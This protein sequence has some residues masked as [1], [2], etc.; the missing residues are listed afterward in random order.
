M[1]SCNTWSPGD[2]LLWLSIM[3]SRSIHCNALLREKNKRICVIIT[4]GTFSQNHNILNCAV[5]YLGYS[6]VRL[7]LLFKNF[8]IFFFF[9]F[10]YTGLSYC[11]WDLVPWPGNLCPLHWEHRVLATDLPGKSLG[12]LIL[13]H[14]SLLTLFNPKMLPSNTWFLETSMESLLLEIDTLT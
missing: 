7:T 2:W 11:M 10:C 14:L 8:L 4:L 5:W 13:Y 6:F 9:F 3:F 12:R 1:E